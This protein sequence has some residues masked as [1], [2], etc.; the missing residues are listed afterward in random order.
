MARTI[1]DNEILAAALTVMAE[2]GYAGA[3]TRQISAA[4]GINEV[5]LFRRFGNKKN[6]LLAAVEQEA[7]NFNV[8]G[9]EYTGDLEADLLRVV[10]FYHNLVKSR[11][12]VLAMLITEAAR[13]PEMLEIMQTPFT[14]M[15]KISQL[16]ERYQEE[17]RLVVE[18]PIYAFVSLV[19]PLFMRELIRFIQPELVDMSFDPAKQVQR[20]LEGR[21]IS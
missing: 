7:E 12:N 5:T 8:A 3:T 10:S 20:Y 11:G 9:I 14:I 17:G 1:S 15:G 4:A 13:Q 21:A 18:P 16:I 6:L 2:Q 19:G